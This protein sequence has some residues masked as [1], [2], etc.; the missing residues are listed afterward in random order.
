[1]CKS[2]APLFWLLLPALG[3]SCMSKAEESTEQVVGGDANVPDWSPVSYIAVGL[4][5]GGQKPFCGG[6]L[7][8]KHPTPSCCACRETNSRTS[9]CSCSAAPDSS[10]SSSMGTRSTSRSCARRGFSACTEKRQGSG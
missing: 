9:R 3:A 1:M 8:G 2:L 6:C 4:A 7:V 10:E 5:C